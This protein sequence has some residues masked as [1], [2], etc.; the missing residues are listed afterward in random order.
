MSTKMIAGKD[1]RYNAK[2]K[3]KGQALNTTANETFATGKNSLSEHIT[4]L[5]GKGKPGKIQGHGG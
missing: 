4:V 2:P 3:P 5:G 1:P